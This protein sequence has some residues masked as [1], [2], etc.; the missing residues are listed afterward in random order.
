M[1]KNPLSALVLA[2][3]A[4]ERFQ[5]MKL[6]IQAMAITAETTCPTSSEWKMCFMAKAKEA[7]AS[8]ISLAGNMP[9]MTVVEA[10]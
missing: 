1:G 4:E 8:W 7:G 3:L 6:A 2:A 10:M 5:T 9:S